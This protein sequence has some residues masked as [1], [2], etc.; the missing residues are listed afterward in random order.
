MEQVLCVYCQRRSAVS[1]AGHNRTGSQRW[2]C[3][4]CQRYF[5]WQRKPLGY[6]PEL[7]QRAVQLYLEGTSLRAMGRLLAVNHQSVA[8]WVRAAAEALPP[9]VTDATATDTIE[10]DEVYTFVGQKKS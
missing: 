2:W 3:A 5:T 7:R 1:K 8:N 4:V 10:I 6:A 9:Q